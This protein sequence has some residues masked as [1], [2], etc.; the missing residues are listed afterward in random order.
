M[1][2]NVIFDDASFDMAGQTVNL[3]IVGLCN[4]MDWS[5]V[6]ALDFPFFAVNG[7]DLEIHGN[8]TF[9]E[10]MFLDVNIPHNIVFRGTSAS[11]TIRLQDN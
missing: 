2:D 1:A 5:Q 11:S 7:N 6:T 10:N 8:L 9:T 3:D 4:D